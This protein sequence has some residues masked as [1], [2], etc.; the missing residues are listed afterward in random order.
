VFVK[1]AQSAA[2]DHLSARLGDDFGEVQGELSEGNIAV[3]SPGV[4]RKSGAEIH[5]HRIFEY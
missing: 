5:P 3:P 4:V 1:A 2:A